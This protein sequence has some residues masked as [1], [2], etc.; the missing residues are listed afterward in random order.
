M[1]WRGDVLAF[2]FAFVFLF[3]RNHLA[4]KGWTKTLYE[5]YYNHKEYYGFFPWNLDEPTRDK[6]FEALRT[7]GSILR[8]AFPANGPVRVVF[9]VDMGHFHCEN[10]ADCQYPQATSRYAVDRLGSLVDLWNINSPH[11][12]GNLREVRKLK[13]EGKVLY[14]YSGTPVVA[15]PLVQSTFWGWRG[16]KYEADGIC[17]WNATDWGDWGT[18]APPADPYTNA[19]GHYQG[20]SMIFY[21]GYKFGYDGPIPSVRLKAMRRGLQDFEY[22]RLIEK[23]GR[24]PRAEL[25]QLA[26][27]LL[28]GKTIDYPKLRRT[29][30]ELLAGGTNS[31]APSSRLCIGGSPN[32]SCG[33]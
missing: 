14:F 25:N 21:P 5:I 26:D 12:W 23:S 30:Y 6:D 16:Y 13:G 15:E 24:K 7:L 32:Q 17:F 3:F 1:V 31:I 4:D 8:E 33:N 9:R 29:I 28:L 19:G 22:L 20:F 11:Y 18:D 27:D 2:S 10:F